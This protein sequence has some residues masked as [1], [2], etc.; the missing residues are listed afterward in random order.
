M[1]LRTSPSSPS[2]TCGMCKVVE[3]SADLLLALSSL[4]VEV[5]EAMIMCLGSL[6]ESQSKG[7]GEGGRAYA[8][9]RG[10]KRWVS[11]E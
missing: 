4:G 10:F 11:C 1:T 9:S 5:G 3:Q 6:C 8:D 2:P 7:E